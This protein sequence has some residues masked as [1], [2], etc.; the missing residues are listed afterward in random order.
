M[1]EQQSVEGKGERQ[2]DKL[3]VQTY[4]WSGAVS[5]FQPC[6][7]PEIKRRRDFAPFNNNPDASAF[8]TSW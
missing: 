1:R 8:Q 7:L 4:S 2:M 5:L 6:P 3:R